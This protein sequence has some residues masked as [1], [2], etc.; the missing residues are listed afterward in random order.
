MSLASLAQPI[1]KSY[2]IFMGQCIPIVE[3]LIDIPSFSILSAS[4][5]RLAFAAT[6]LIQSMNGINRNGC[7][8]ALQFFIPRSIFVVVVADER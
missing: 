3:M 4:S 1:T 6:K 2:C 7:A 8:R 5:S